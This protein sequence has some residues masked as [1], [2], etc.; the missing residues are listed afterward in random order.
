VKIALV[1]PIEE[2]VP[3]TKYGGTERV[4]ASLA[5]Q[6]IELGHDVTLLASGDS[7]SKAKLVPVIERSNRSYIRSE[8][9]TWFNRQVDA[10]YKTV[11]TLDKQNFDIIHNHID[12]TLL[13]FQNFLKT[14]IVTTFHGPV[15]YFTNTLYKDQPFVSISDSQRKLAKQ[16]NYVATVHNAIDVAKFT[17]NDKPDDYLVFLGRFHPDKGPEQ[18]IEIARRTGRKLIMAA[19]VDPL[20]RAYFDKSLRPLI[21]DKQ[22]VYMGEVDQKEKIKLLGRAQALLSPIQWE[23]PFGLVNIEALAC[24]T[25][26]VTMN[27]GS[28][29][30]IIKDGQ[31]GFICTSL[32]EMVERLKEVGKIS[33]I[34]CRRHAEKYFDSK[35]MAERYLAAYQKVIDQFKVKA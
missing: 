17:F 29:P 26:V 4:I 11:N 14:P 25:P 19:K 6:L 33:R 27:R 32:D 12:A 15:E 35:L 13:L 10:L 18:A 23:E 7:V 1:A 22:I 2:S 8:P 5:D 9:R 28:M 21:D 30:E 31:V 20:D 24:G 16:L 34:N 3:P